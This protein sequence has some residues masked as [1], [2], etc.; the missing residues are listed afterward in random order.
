MSLY[1][2]STAIM[3]LQGAIKVGR[4]LEEYKY[5]YFEEPVMYD[6]FE[7][8]KA[9]RMRLSYRFQTVSRDTSFVNFRWLLA[10]TA[11]L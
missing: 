3:M 2:D 8:I 11:L 1:A 5:R 4:L 10:M 6:H 9:L 7:D